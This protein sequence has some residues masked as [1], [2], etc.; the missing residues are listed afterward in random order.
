MS[1]AFRRPASGA[2]RWWALLSQGF[3]SLT[4]GFIPPPLRGSCSGLL[5]RR[6]VAAVTE[7]PQKDGVTEYD[8]PEYGLT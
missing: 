1:R 6:E 5:A 7:C 2:Y 4:L 3:A 8:Q